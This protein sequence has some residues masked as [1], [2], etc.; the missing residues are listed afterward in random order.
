MAI[1]PEVPKLNFITRILTNNWVAALV[2]SI[3]GYSLYVLYSRGK[4][5]EA[6]AG[7]ILLA[8]ALILIVRGGRRKPPD[9]PR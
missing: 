5:L 3:A 7:A 1:E 4:I 6:A 9:F 2:L 8:L